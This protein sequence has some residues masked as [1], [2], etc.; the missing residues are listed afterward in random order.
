MT[1]PA[2]TTLIISEDLHDLVINHPDAFVLLARITMLAKAGTEPG[3]AFLPGHKALGMTEKRYRR[4]KQK[5]GQGRTEGGLGAFTGAS[6]GT[7]VTLCDSMTYN[8]NISGKGGHEGRQGAN[9]GPTEGKS[10]KE[11]EIPPMTISNPLLEK[12]I[13]QKKEND[14]R[15]RVRCFAPP[16][17][18]QVDEY[19]TEY[20][21][22]KGKR[23]DFDGEMFC[24][25]YEAVN[26]FR[27]K[28]KI[29]S[30]KG[31]VRTWALNSTANGKVGDGPQ[32]VTISSSF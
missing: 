11:K 32:T 5:L 29:I 2:P 25:H 16:T 18:A 7:R 19:I 1:D 6:K 20:S 14:K 22:K 10:S 23:F 12:E 3:K 17:P 27:G 8:M 4:A 26:W 13:A 9:K 30:W 31:C 15:K 21:K 28:S 24:A